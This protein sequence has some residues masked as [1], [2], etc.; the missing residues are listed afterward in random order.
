M[1]FTPKLRLMQKPDLDVI[2]LL[3]EKE[4]ICVPYQ[5]S[6]S[7]DEVNLG[8]KFEAINPGKQEDVISSILKHYGGVCL[9]HP[10][11][12]G[13]LELYDEKLTCLGSYQLTETGI[14]NSKGIVTYVEK[15]DSVGRHH[16]LLQLNRNS[17]EGE[18]S[19]EKS[20]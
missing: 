2:L 3:I 4:G 5:V 1:E 18:I 6:S 11:D 20:S 7:N 10:G 14:T 12:S 15:A 8:G 19:K 9:N 17:L 16:S 13:H